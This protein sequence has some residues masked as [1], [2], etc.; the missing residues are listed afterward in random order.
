MSREL[1]YD[2]TVEGAVHGMHHDC[3][4]IGFLGAQKI[5]RASDIR[6]DSEDQKWDIWLIVDGKEVIP[7]LP[8]SGFAGYDEARKFEVEALNACRKLG[9]SADS[10]RGNCIIEN[11][12]AGHPIPDGDG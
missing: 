7:T 3:F 8:L 2:F 4:N 1:V 12:R 11:L 9:V 6:F 10:I 5:Q